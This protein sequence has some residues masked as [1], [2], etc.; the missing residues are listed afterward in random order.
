MIGVLQEEI[1]TA[2]GKHITVGQ[3]NVAIR[4][5]RGAT[6]STLEIEMELLKEIAPRVTRVTALG[7]RRPRRHTCGLPQGREGR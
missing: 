1:L 7:A 5:D 3:D 2:L 4:M 6:L